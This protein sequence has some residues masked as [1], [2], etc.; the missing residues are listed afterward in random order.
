[1]AKKSHVALRTSPTNVLL[2]MGPKVNDYRLKEWN[3]E[4]LTG[5][6]EAF[7]LP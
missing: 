4:R 7:I 1:M 5:V 6:V 2:N 3:K